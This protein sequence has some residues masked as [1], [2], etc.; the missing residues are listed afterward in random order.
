MNKEL[1]LPEIPEKEPV[2]LVVVRLR[3]TCFKTARGAAWRKDIDYQ[4]KL[5]RGFNF[6]EEDIAM[7]GFSEVLDRVQNLHTHEDGLYEIQ[8]CNVSKDWETGHVDSWDYKLVPF[9]RIK[10]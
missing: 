5:C 9:N 3:T 7:I 2:S 10:Q 8:M 4:K 1:L 6:F